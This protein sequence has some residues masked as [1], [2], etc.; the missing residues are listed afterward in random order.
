MQKS[1]T[2]TFFSAGLTDNGWTN[3]FQCFE[4]FRNVFIPQTHARAKLYGDK[5]NPILLVFDGHGSH[6]TDELCEEAIENDIHFFK[7]Q[8]HTTHKTWPCNVRCFGPMS[9]KWLERMEEIVEDTGD[10]LQWH[11]F[12]N[13]YMAVHEKSI[14]KE[15]ILAAFKKTGI[16]PFNPNIFTAADFAPSCTLSTQA[17]MPPSFSD[18]TQP[19]SRTCNEEE[20]SVVSPETSSDSWA[21]L[22]KD[23]DVVSNNVGVDAQQNMTVG[24]ATAANFIWYNDTYDEDPIGA[25]TPTIPTPMAVPIEDLSTSPSDSDTPSTEFTNQ[26]AI[27]AL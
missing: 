21:M 24:P 3:D 10:G 17:H 7:L 12:V 20:A 9:K 16:S 4:W 23:A 14:T 25:V 5:N 6:L 13:K 1:L 8:A 2:E 19:C 22:I 15:C 27:P 26:P 11:N 18:A